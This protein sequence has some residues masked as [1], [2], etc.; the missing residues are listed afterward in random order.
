MAQPLKVLHL[1]HTLHTGGLERIVVDLVGRAA[2]LNIVPEAA[3]LEEPGGLAVQVRRLGAPVHALDK[4]PGLDWR[5]VGRLRRLV[6]R[7]GVRVIH[8]HNEGAGLYGGLAGHWAGVPV[9]LTRHGPGQA[10]G[11]RRWLLRV[12]VGRLASVTACVSRDVMRRLAHEEKVPAYRLRLVYNGVD[13]ERY[14]P[15]RED[16]FGLRHELGI[17]EDQPVV[18]S[19]GRLAPEKAY[20]LLLEAMAA[21]ELAA[22][23]ARLVLAG[24]GP[25]RGELVQRAGEMGLGDRVVFL[26][27]RPDV[28]RLLGMGRVFALSS[29]LEG[30]SMAMLEAMSSGLAVAAT[31]VGGNPEVVR[32]GT[33]G[34]LS[35]PGQAEPL[36]QALIRIITEPG[37]AQAMG[38]AGRERVEA[39]FSLDA[40]TAAYAAIY[41]ELA[42]PRRR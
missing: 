35:P 18:V 20:H 36:A 8:A 11:L 34:L 42:A 12:L 6:A 23:G 9:V 39:R 28:D 4:R 10:G 31:R 2:A 7:E 17:A 22:A 19:V 13:T 32:E 29:E 5:V 24:D 40:M 25:C 26:G 15:G 27:D 1:S 30:V 16:A 41:R 37:L 21:P 3:T 33:T 38:R 14:R